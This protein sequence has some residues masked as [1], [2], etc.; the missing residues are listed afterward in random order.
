MLKKLRVGISLVIITLITFYFLDFAELLPNGFHWLAK[1]QLIPALLALN[2][3]VL[4]GLI[5]TT[6]LFGRIYCS[7]ICPM[8][9]FQDIVGRIT[10]YFGK[11]KKRHQYNQAR[12]RWRWSVLVVVIIALSLGF[13]LLVGILD[14]YSA[15]GRMIVTVFKPIYMAGNNLLAF[16]FSAFGNYVFYKVDITIR[17]VF[18]FV[19]GVVT[20]ISI[21]FL[22]WKYSRLYCNTVC[23]VGTVLG[24]LSKYSLFRIK[25]DP[26][27]CNKCGLCEMK[28]KAFC[29]NSEEQAIDYSRC[30]VC[31]NCLYSCKHKALNF[32]SVLM[33]KKETVI[34][35]NNK[36]VDTGKRKFLLTMV[37]SVMAIP[38]TFAQNKISI[39]TKG[40]P[41]KRLISL[42]P[43]G[44]LSVDHLLD[45]CSS[46]QLCIG[47]CPSHVL[48]PAYMEYG[49]GGMMQPVMDFEKG[50]CNF[51]CIVCSNICPN[52]A[53]KP[54]TMGE[55][56]L[57][58]IG[59]VVFIKENCI[60][61]TEDT[62]CGAC[63]EH[64][65]TQAVSMVPYKDGLTIP[66][67]NPD[68]CVGC[69]ACEYIC[70]VRPYRAIYIEGN[71]VH[72]QAQAFKE[73]EKKAIKV[74]DFGF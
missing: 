18:A 32:T 11:K 21:G 66:S 60:V 17:S 1:I 16:V 39:L 38:A 4:A 43:P 69:G 35:K 58:Q 70:P 41:Y 57:T 20:F 28:C 33:E 59:H 73:A 24:F 56:H 45:H 37:I 3:V 54:L 64:C 23:P 72:K 27:K 7:V 30:V 51:D 67:I 14:P 74:D 71:K 29:L 63:S 53:L 9:I 40:K 2:A 6:M 10:G 36:P 47:K 12:N 15:Y 22:A 50:F 26:D 5:L 31:F 8:G 46:C 52:G 68:I 44:S 55:K 19:V 34:S 13:T 49:L 42:S 61:H 25:I 48:K 65:P 62:N